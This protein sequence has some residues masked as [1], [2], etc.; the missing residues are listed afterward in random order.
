MEQ[1]AIE[2]FMREAIRLSREGSQAGKGGPFGAVIVKDNQIIGK[3]SNHVLLTNDPTAHAEVVAIRD[4]CA[5]LQ[6]FHLDDCVLFTSCEPCPMCLG[7][8]YWARISKIYYA[9]NR[10]DAANIGFNDDFIYQELDLP[11]DK[12]HIPMELLL[13][14]EA[15]AVFKNWENIK[16]K[17]LY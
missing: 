13:R 15:Q 9:N 7:A 4:A 6:T 11:I 16:N 12:R 17:K 5:N 2:N 10:K 3:G 14:E 8:I 1:Q